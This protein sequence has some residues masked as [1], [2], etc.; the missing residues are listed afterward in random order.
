MLLPVLITLLLQFSAV[1]CQAVDAYGISLY[2]KLEVMERMML[3]QAGVDV[4][5]NPCSNFRTGAPILG[6]VTSA[7]WV[8]IVFHDFVTADVAAG[9]GSVG[10]V[11]FLGGV[12]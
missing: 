3:A 6:E 11:L 8:R 9:T 1:K 4:S 10:L 2:D 7:E 12:C 5:V